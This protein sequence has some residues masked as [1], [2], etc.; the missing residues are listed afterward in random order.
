MYVL[1]DSRSIN[2]IKILESS[3]IQTFSTHYSDQ[4][5]LLGQV[6][7]PAVQILVWYSDAI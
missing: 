5:K 6:I 7:S 2:K 4:L 1:F 3:E